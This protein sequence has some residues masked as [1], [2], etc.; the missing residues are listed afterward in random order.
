MGEVVSFP[1]RS[2]DPAAARNLAGVAQARAA[3]RRGRARAI[4]LEVDVDVELGD[5]EDGA[6]A[7]DLRV[8]DVADEARS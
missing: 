4:D 8:G 1:G 7:P 5:D 3:L 2:A 6:R